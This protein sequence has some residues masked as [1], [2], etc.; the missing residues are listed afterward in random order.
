MMLELVLVFL[1]ILKVMIIDLFIKWNKKYIKYG[2]N[3]LFYYGKLLFK[4]GGE[5]FKFF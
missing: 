3:E 2:K 4:E 5:Y 1:L